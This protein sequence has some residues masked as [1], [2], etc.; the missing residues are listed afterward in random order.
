MTAFQ[1]YVNGFVFAANA[2]VSKL[3][4]S[5]KATDLEVAAACKTTKAYKE[6]S[7]LAGRVNEMLSVQVEKVEEPK[8]ST[9]NRAGEPRRY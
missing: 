6:N 7:T 2:K 5:G 3:L 1:N 8:Q 4:K 9:S